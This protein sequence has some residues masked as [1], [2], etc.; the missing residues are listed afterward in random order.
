MPTENISD[1]SAQSPSYRGAIEMESGASAHSTRTLVAMLYHKRVYSDW[2]G[3]PTLEDLKNEVALQLETQERRLD[4]FISGSEEE[5]VKALWWII[6]NGLE[7]DL[8]LIRQI[9]KS[10]PYSSESVTRLLDIAEQRIFRRINEPY[11]VMIRGQQ[12][13]RSNRIEW[14]REYSNRVIA[15]HCG[16]VVASAPTR[17]ELMKE[18]AR[19]QKT[20]GPFRAYIVDVGGPTFEARGPMARPGL[21][22]LRK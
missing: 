15:I 21:Q 5:F 17:D 2:A 8:D 1:L 6:E 14:E 13:Y 10:P 9:S 22:T 12:A 3:D 20:E 7:K 4:L 16:R 11:R 18:I 19:A